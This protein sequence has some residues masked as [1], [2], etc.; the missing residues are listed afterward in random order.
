[1][2]S[3]P[4]NRELC[5]AVGPGFTYPG[6]VTWVVPLALGG[7]AIIVMAVFTSLAAR[8]RQRSSERPATLVGPRVLVHDINDDRCTGRR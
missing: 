8:K 6:P 4:I 3:Q 2:G 1:M 5:V 7:V